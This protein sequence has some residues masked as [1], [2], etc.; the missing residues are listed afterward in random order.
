MTT[1]S[2]VLA[3]PIKKAAVVR[4]GVLLIES[5]VASKRGLS[6]M[7]LKGGYKAVK[8]LK[9]GIIAEALGMLLPD[10]A[11]AIDPI[12]LRGAASGDPQA[13]LCANASEVA[14]ALLEVTDGKAARAKNRVMI[15]VYQSLR[16]QA[17]GHVVAAI[18]GLA[19]MVVK[20]VG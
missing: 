20:H 7:A 6:G 11:P 13:Y 14:D 19:R 12:Y 4:D 16:A 1:L 3:D 9:P 8:K 18:P 17:R 5:E 10:F 2:G 15:R